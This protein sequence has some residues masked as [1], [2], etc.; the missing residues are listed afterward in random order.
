MHLLA[1]DYLSATHTPQIGLSRTATLIKSA[2]AEVPQSLLFDTGDFL[3][4]NVLGDQVAQHDQNVAKLHPAIAAMNALKYDGATL[5]NHEFS[6][7][8]GFLLD[9]LISA[10]FPLVLANVARTL[11]P[12][13]SADQTLLHPYRIL[14]K[15]LRSGSGAKR[16]IRVGVVGFVPPQTAVWDRHA[17]QG[18]LH[19]RDIVETARDYLPRMK[20]DGA[21]LIVA[22]AHSGIAAPDDPQVRENAVLPLSNLDGIDV[23]LCGHQ[24][25]LFPDPAFADL[26]GVDIGNGT[27]NGKPTMM[28]GFWGSHLGV[29]DLVLGPDDTGGWKIRHHHTDLRPIYNGVP[30]SGINETIAE[31]PEIVAAVR[32]HHQSTLNHIEKPVGTTRQP[33]NTFFALVADD[34]SL[35]LV[36]RAQADYVGRKLHATP[37]AALPLLSAVSPYKAGGQAGAGNFTDIGTGPLTLRSLAD[38][39]PFP[40]EI[41]AVRLTGRD[42]VEWLERCAALFHRILHGLRQ[43]ALH[44]PVF[45]SYSFDHIVGLEYRIDPSQPPRYTPDG[46]F[47]SSENRR[48]SAITWRARPIDP[49]QEFIVAT[50]SFRASGGGGFA[51]VP[52]EKMVL[53]TG[54]PIREIL[55]DYIR[56]QGTVA[57]RPEPVWH[58]CPLIGTSAQFKTSLSAIE[59]LATVPRRNLSLDSISEDGFATINIDF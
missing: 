12:R 38:L 3:Q 35:Q 23:I 44:N 52:P 24:H 18:Q 14:Q 41:C 8:L 33:L 46:K 43:Q 16:T 21:D 57:V 36:A 54:E 31:A 58:F 28:P 9:S 48:I 39:Y 22:L 1:Y 11:G 2:R 42:I 49:G 34:A 56:Q 15:T 19:F 53:E 55:G 4:G 25:R 10:R 47:V 27:I 50:N 30:Q 59:R 51:P 45:P 40:N 26:P 5:G 20:A 29:M 17:V 7:G 13:P 6:Y 37:D 32:H